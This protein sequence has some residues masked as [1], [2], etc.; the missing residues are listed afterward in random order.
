[1]QCPRC[2]ARDRH[3]LLAVYLEAASPVARARPRILHVAPESS[4]AIV[5]ERL[6][7]AGYRSVDVEPGA[8][9]TAADIT[10]L[11]FGEGSFDLVICSHVLEH[12][13]DD[14][15]ALSEL[16]RVVSER[17]EVLLLTPVNHEL[18]TTIED[19]AASADERRRR[20]GQHDHV[21]IYGTD[22]VE[23]IRAAGLVASRFD[24]GDVDER[25]RRHAGLRRDFGAYGL[26]NELFA[27]AP[28]PRGPAVTVRDQWTGSRR[29]G[30]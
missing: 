13:A 25:L 1:M 27:C 24:A 11:P 12:V 4:V 19:A 21:R 9:D 22:L 16:A 10:D 8:A 26:R 29:R 7:H 3:R 30:R 23:R 15:R 14:R 28:A 18:E 20:F 17:G 6:G 2:G 5:L